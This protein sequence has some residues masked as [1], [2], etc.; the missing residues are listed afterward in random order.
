MMA[1][2][3]HAGRLIAGLMCVVL[4]VGCSRAV[5]VPR[6]QFDAAAH[7]EESVH[8]V[9]TTSGDTYIVARFFHHRFDPHD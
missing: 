1:A 4:T 9:R 6:E 7:S 2:R 3:M 5:E 8:T